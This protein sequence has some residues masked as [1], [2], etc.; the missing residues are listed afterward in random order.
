MV[1]AILIDKSGEIKA[2]NIKVEKDELYKKCKFKSTD[3]FS[4]RH[5]WKVD[6]SWSKKNNVEFKYISV[7][8]K[9]SGRANMENKFD[10]PPPIDKD[11][12]F[13]S[14]I[15]L[16]HELKNL[17]SEQDYDE[18]KEEGTYSDLEDKY[19]EYVDPIDLSTIVWNSFYD[20]QFGGFEDLSA[21]ILQDENEEDELDQ[22][23]DKMKTS[24]GYLKD[25]F[26]VDDDEDLIMD[27]DHIEGTSDESEFTT[28]G[29]QEE[30]Q[31]EEYEYSDDEKLLA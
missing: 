5:T 8:A 7:Y 9:D 23:P 13:G 11:L 2:V 21:S 18:A 4:L 29:E 19:L 24:T 25:D 30:L 26:V 22:I 20:N 10:L 6:K 12:Y 14:I 31:F 16:A 3:S 28:S 27:E 1:K 15:I 17:M